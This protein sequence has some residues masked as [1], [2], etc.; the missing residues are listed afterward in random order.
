MLFCTQQY[1]VAK[2]GSEGSRRPKSST[3]SG[4]RDGV[5]ITK[6]VVWAVL[7]LRVSATRGVLDRH[8]GSSRPSN[9]GTR[10]RLF[11]HR[12]AAAGP[13]CQWTNFKSDLFGNAWINSGASVL[14]RDRNPGPKPD[15]GCRIRRHNGPGPLCCEPEPPVNLSSARRLTKAT[16][17]P[18]SCRR[19]AR[20]MA[21][22]PPPTTATRAPEKP[23][24]SRWSKLCDKSWFGSAPKISGTYRKGPTPIAMTRRRALTLSPLSRLT[25]SSCQSVQRGDLDFRQPRHATLLKSEA[26]VAEN[27]ESNRLRFT[28]RDR[29]L[30]GKSGECI[31][32]LRV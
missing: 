22:A 29:L 23:E 13:K 5:V 26:V 8:G 9:K 4:R 17:H 10:P 11:F 30:F 1:P 2:L 15:D 16:S 18:R 12:L 3:K 7:L 31:E 27:I 6:N 28:V 19:P 20:S 25:T 32:V 24:R 21:E 14:K